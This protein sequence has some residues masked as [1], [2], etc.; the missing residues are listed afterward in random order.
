[1]IGAAQQT[2]EPGILPEQILA[3]VCSAT[4]KGRHQGP[5]RFWWEFF[6]RVWVRVIPL[7]PRLLRIYTKFKDTGRKF[8]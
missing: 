6:A 4:R 7:R 2:V 1:M 8:R 3:V 5:G